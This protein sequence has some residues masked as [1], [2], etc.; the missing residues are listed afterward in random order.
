MVLWWWWLTVAAAARLHPR[1]WMTLPRQ[2]EEAERRG[3]WTCDGGVRTKTCCSVPFTQRCR[4]AK[5][6]PPAVTTPGRLYCPSA[7]FF[8]RRREG[9]LKKLYNSSAVGASLEAASNSALAAAAAVRADK[10]Y[11]RRNMSMSSRIWSSA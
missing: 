1:T 8:L 7:V 6:N 5:E 3:G 9:Y 11:R 2:E 10:A 4:E